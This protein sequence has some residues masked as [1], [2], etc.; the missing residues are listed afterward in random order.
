MKATQITSLSLGLRPREVCVLMESMKAPTC[1]LRELKLNCL[2]TATCLRQLS[3][4]LL[5]GETRLE[6]LELGFT[7][8]K[9]LELSELD[10]FACAVASCASLKALDFQGTALV[11]MLPAF[12]AA[13]G[14]E[15]LQF[16]H[17]GVNED[18]S[19]LGGLLCDSEKCSLKRLGLIYYAKDYA[20][21]ALDSFSQAVN[22]SRLEALWI[23]VRYEGDE[24]P[25]PDKCG[26]TV[27]R[28]EQDFYQSRGTKTPSKKAK[29]D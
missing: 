5:S 8:G 21:K 2:V 10:A 18:L 1:G 16:D 11:P 6:R 27:V 23:F 22:A 20:P 3:E 7:A 19:A 26:K 25:K 15:E 13:G 14:L 9:K 17:K 12:V 29:V 4:L 28:I 24:I